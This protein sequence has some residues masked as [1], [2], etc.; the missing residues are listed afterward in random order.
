MPSKER[1]VER[2]GGWDISYFP[3]LQIAS[4]KE[5]KGM[6]MRGAKFCLARKLESMKV[7]PSIL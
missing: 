7:Y 5:L 2:G 3:P 1:Q 4:S 6:Y